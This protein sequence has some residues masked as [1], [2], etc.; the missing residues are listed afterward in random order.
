MGYH[1]TPQ[2][3]NMSLN[4]KRN[5]FNDIV[6]VLRIGIFAR[7]NV[8]VCSICSFFDVVGSLRQS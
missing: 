2:Q 7:R 3:E 1:K 5:I 6:V 4:I 8:L